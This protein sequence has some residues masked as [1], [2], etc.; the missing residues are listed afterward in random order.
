MKKLLLSILCLF[1]VIS[2]SAQTMKIYKGETLVA[3]YAA[4]KAD[5]VVFQGD[6]KVSS[7]TLNKTSI[8]IYK[9]SNTTLKA[10]VQPEEAGDKTVIWSTSDAS[11][12]TVADGVVTA[13]EVG[14]ATI[15]ALAN[16]GSGIKATCAVTVTDDPSDSHEYVDLGLPSGTLWATCNIGAENITDYGD[17]FAWG[18]TSGYNSGK[19]SFE[20]ATYSY[21][22]ENKPDTIIEK[23]EQGFETKTITYHKG[24]TKYVKSKDASKN[25]YDGLYD[26]KTT[27]ESIDDAATINWGSK[28]QIPTKTQWTE[29]I[30]NC[31]WTWCILN[32][33]KGCKVIATNGN[34]IFLPAAGYRSSSNAGG[35]GFYWSSNL[36]SLRESYYAAYMYFYSTSHESD[37]QYRFLGYSV[38][39]VRSK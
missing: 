11:I 23:D 29:L 3:T 21:Y 1:C 13:V 22:K 24:Y 15:T 20:V 36:D 10:T 19:T 27:L 39:P 6:T 5:K 12:A 17:Y 26:D 32:D 37:Y 25:G 16:D 18:E 14:T 2:I 33:V 38:R 30:S 31:T 7:I 8:N 4:D 35:S 9:G 34:Y 28:W